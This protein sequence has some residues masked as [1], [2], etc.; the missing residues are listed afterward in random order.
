MTRKPI[1]EWVIAVGRHEGFIPSEEWIE[2][3]EL[4]AKIAEKYNR[5]HRRTNAL[6]AGI[7]FCPICGRHLNCKKPLLKQIFCI[8]DFRIRLCHI[9]FQTGKI[10][11]I[12]IYHL[13]AEPF[14]I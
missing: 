3:Q 12:C 9:L 10:S 5:P 7:I 2:T 8:L 14:S 1:E 11:I 4:L 6:L 13:I